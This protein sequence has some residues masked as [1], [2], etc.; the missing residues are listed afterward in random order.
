MQDPQSSAPSS[1]L[2]DKSLVA[3][4]ATLSP[5]QRLAELESRVAFF[6]SLRHDDDAEFS[7]NTGS[8]QQAPD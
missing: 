1:A 4:F 3:W 2:H 6:W 8:S 5:E 7:R